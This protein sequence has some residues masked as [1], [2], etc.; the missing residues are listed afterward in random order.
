M[1]ESASFEMFQKKLQGICDEHDLIARFQ[2][3]KYPIKMVIQPCNNFDSQ[4]SMMES[5]SDDGSGYISQDASITFYMEDGE[6]GERIKGTFDISDTLKTKLKT[7]FK[8]LH[9]LYLQHFHRELIQNKVLNSIPK[10]EE[11][12]VAPNGEIPI[13]DFLLDELGEE[14]PEGAEPSNAPTGQEESE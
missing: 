3:D 8:K 10:I 12:D 7:M 14:P 2:Y 4:L 1:K 11:E 6:L 9:F 13:E 5:V